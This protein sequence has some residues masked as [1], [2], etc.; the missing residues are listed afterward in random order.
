[1]TRRSLLTLWLMG[2]TFP[3][4]A[5]RE[6]LLASLRPVLEKQLA[7][8]EATLRRPKPVV[9][10]RELSNGA[11]AALLLVKEPARAEALLRVLFSV[12]DQDPTSPKLGEIPWR[13]ND[14]TVNDPNAMMFCAQALGPI[15][16][17]YGEQ[18]SEVFRREMT[19]A[20]RYLF[21]ALKQ[22][23]FRT[24][25]YTNIFL[26]RAVSTILM[27]EA[28]HDTEMADYGYTQFDDWLRYTRTVGISE[29]NSPTY[30]AVDLNVLTVGYRYAARP[31]ARDRFRAVLD[32]FWADIAANY[33]AGR[34]SYAGPHARDYDFI[35]GWGGGMG[36][37]FQ[38]VGLKDDGTANMIGF[39]KVYPLLNAQP[40]GYHPPDALLALT[41]NPTR[42]VRSR[43]NPSPNRDRYHYLTPEFTIGAA[44]G[45][46][47]AEGK[48][49]SVELASPK[50]MP[51]ICVV[52]D[53]FDAPYGRV[54][55]A[56]GSGH[57]KPSHLPG[58]CLAVQEKGTLLVLL[59]A[60]ATRSKDPKIASLA[61]NLLLPARA[62]AISVDGQRITPYTPFTRTTTPS[63]VLTIHE[64]NA[65]VAIRFLS[66][67]GLEGYTPTNVLQ[68]DS[69]GLAVDVLR[70]TFY[71]YR[72]TATPLKETAARVALL[73]VAERCKTDEEVES[74]TRRV[75]TA[76]I[77]EEQTIDRWGIRVTLPDQALAAALHLTTRAVL[78]RQINGKD[79][80]PFLPLE[81]RTPEG[82]VILPELPK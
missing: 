74:L 80:P 6:D 35:G 62:S 79:L 56:D 16:I 51:S 40:G 39:E 67:V 26:M 72:G 57:E 1:M 18:L 58:T 9:T 82:S 77:E 44:S 5:Y 78:T 49:V 50:K 66:G 53:T 37:Y 28:V 65:A 17:G 4:A 30:T 54:R 34:G 76:K 33:F 32:F 3:S 24:P 61:T 22:R 81:V 55:R 73:L 25:A 41:R 12:Q 20:I 29:F 7:D 38:T 8:L 31:G 60:D 13:T 19:T 59:T 47:G 10:T 36:Y 14:P 48:P 75:A 69:D 63:T 71:H 11:L 70:W 68:A 46:F 2:L 64:G 42:I 45:D 23:N 43:W 15:L 27:G 52:P 21:A